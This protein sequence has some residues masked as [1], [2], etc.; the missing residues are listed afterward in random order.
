MPTKV[1]TRYPHEPGYAVAPG[2]TLAETIAALHM[3]QRELAIR[4]GLSEKH[5][6]RIINGHAAVTPETAAKLDRVTR[7]PARV[8]SNLEATY[9][10]RRAQIAERERLKHDID[11][12]KT[13]PVGELVRRGLIPAAKDKIARIQAVLR[14]F[15]V[16]NPGAWRHYYLRANPAYRKSAAFQAKPSATATWFRIG[17][18]KAQEVHSAPYNAS[19]FMKAL[20]QIRKLTTDSPTVF[21]PKMKSLCAEAGVVLVF[22]REIKGCPVSG[23]A[24]WLSPTKALIQMGLRHKTDDQFWFT[25]FHEAGHILHDG[26]KEIFI[27]DDRHQ[28]DGEE[29]ANRF[30]ADFL[31]PPEATAELGTLATRAAIQDFAKRIGIAPGIVVGRLQHDGIIPFSYLNDL[32]KRFT[33]ADQ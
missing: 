8:W 33:W 4:A 24:R 19:Q 30:A 17:E 1:T 22:V 21:E 32:K 16:D 3:D 5:V 29:K 12:L 11:W 9:Q 15:G 7:V 27:D 20:E 25:F 26:K 13:I 23:L 31:I 6:S 18:L 2:E 10:E 28:D 14:F